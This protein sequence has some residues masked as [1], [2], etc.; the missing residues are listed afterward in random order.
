MESINVKIDDLSMLNLCDDN[1]VNEPKENMLNDTK[2]PIDV[3]SSVSSQ[4]DEN[5]SHIEVSSSFAFRRDREVEDNFINSR[6][7][8]NIDTEAEDDDD[9]EDVDQTEVSNKKKG[10]RHRRSI[11]SSGN[12]RKNNGRAWI[13]ILTLL[14]KLCRLD[15]RKLSGYM[16]P[17]YAIDGIFSIKSDVFS[18]GILLLELV[19]GKKNRG[20]YH[21]D[22]NLS[23][24]G[25][26]WKLWKEGRLLEL[27]DPFLGESCNK[28]EAIRVHPH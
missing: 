9:D 3:A 1:G 2:T 13:V 20:F 4:D 22:C 11:G 19:S 5:D 8:V 7:H 28:S 27:I 15:W 23:L 6:A 18:F 21:P 10:K 17:E 24:I 25:Y 14:K 26:A 12:R 16:A